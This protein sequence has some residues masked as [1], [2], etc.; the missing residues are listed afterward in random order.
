MQEEYGKQ[1]YISNGMLAEASTCTRV[2]MSCP[3]QLRSMQAHEKLLFVLIAHLTFNILTAC[4]GLQTA[5]LQCLVPRLTCMKM[6]PL[7]I[8]VSQ[9]M[10]VNQT[11]ELVVCLSS[12]VTCEK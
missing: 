4:T 2:T 8:S 11:F 5:Y 6:I 1:R 3:Q 9:A 10:A 12:P 7:Y